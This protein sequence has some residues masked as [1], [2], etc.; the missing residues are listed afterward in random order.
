MRCL[1]TGRYKYI[2]NLAPQNVYETHIS[3]G[4]GVDGKTYW[5]SWKR[6]A[7]SDAH[8]KAVVERYHKRPAE[9][10]HDL[11]KDPHELRNV[12]GEAG[13]AETLA[14]LREEVKRWRVEQ[15]E[16]LGKVPMPEDARTGEVPYAK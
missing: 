13:Y 9:E 8:A 11:E 7:E 2:L 10:L 4:A 15:G 1:R 12:A 6:L 5:D 3:A 16:D 14:E